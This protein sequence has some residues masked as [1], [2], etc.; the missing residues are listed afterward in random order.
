MFCLRIRRRGSKREQR[1][2][3]R[4]IVELQ[5][6]TLASGQKPSCNS[7]LKKANTVILRASGEDARG[8]STSSVAITECL[9]ALYPQPQIASPPCHFFTTLLWQRYND[10]LERAGRSCVETIMCVCYV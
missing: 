8:I 7:L 5:K 6:R 1:Q 2:N 4:H 9:H 10:I 3:D